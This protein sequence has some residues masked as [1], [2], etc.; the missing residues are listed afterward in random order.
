MES[1]LSTVEIVT[2]L[3]I[4]E[5]EINLK[6]MKYNLLSQVIRD[7]YPDLERDDYF[8]EKKILT[9]AKTK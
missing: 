5:Q 9:D 7:R 1:K 8:L 4:L 2:E 6:I 3:T